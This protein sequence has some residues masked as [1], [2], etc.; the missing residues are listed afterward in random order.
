MYFDIKNLY[1]FDGSPKELSH[2][3]V[4]G[5]FALQYLSRFLESHLSIS[6]NKICPVTA[7][8]CSE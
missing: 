1:K 8:S 2:W 6:T 4:L 7:Q 5:N 3:L